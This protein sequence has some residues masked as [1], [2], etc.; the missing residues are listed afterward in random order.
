MISKIL[1]T[2]ILF[3]SLCGASYA[4]VNNKQVIVD[5]EG[6]SYSQAVANGLENAVLQLKGVDN[7]ITQQQ[8]YNLLSQSDD[9][10]LVDV[11]PTSRLADSLTKATDGHISSYKVV[12]KKESKGQYKLNLSVNV[13]ENVADEKQKLQLKKIVILPFDVKEGAIT[14]GGVSDDNVSASLQ[15]G[16]INQFTQSRKF[17]V[18][19]KNNTDYN[20][21]KNAVENQSKLKASKSGDYV[22]LGSVLN[23]TIANKESSYY[24]SSFSNWVVT[25]TV[26]YKLIDLSSMEVKWANTEPITLPPSI[27]NKYID[28]NNGAH[29]G[30]EQY[31]FRDMSKTIAD[32]VIGV[33]YPLT[34][35]K[36]WD[37]DVYLNQ[38]GNRV[39]K[40]NV[41]KLFE[42]GDV[43]QDTATGQLITLNGKNVATVR[44]TDVMPKYSVGQIIDG[45]SI[46]VRSGDKAY[47]QDINN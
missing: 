25:A 46:N 6:S 7:K 12:D 23:L 35:V 39:V 24:G 37:N 11:A 9:K 1:K 38:G 26:A 28:G 43:V 40:G 5:G 31:L 15:Q 14:V 21:Y 4:L 36:V 29:S 16:L 42:N 30:V 27:A 13:S 18:I 8:L 34:V 22:I 19:D 32:Q 2:S 17:R 47:F 45:S 3:A 20:K 44:I 10:S 33:A 41:Y